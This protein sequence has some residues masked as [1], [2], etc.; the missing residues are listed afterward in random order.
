[1]LSVKVKVSKHSP[2]KL[3]FATNIPL[4]QGIVGIMGHSGCG[5]TTLLRVLTGLETRY[6]GSLSV[7]GN[8]LWDSE[9]KV[10]VPTHQ[11]GIG[12]VFQDARLFPHLTVLGNLQ[13]AAKRA[14]EQRFDIPQV[15]QWFGLT[16]LLE[17]PATTLSGGQKQRLAV[18][19]AVLQSPKLLLLDEPF[20]ALDMAARNELLVCLKKMHIQ[21]KLPMLF[22]SHDIADIRQLCEYLLVMEQGK[23]VMNGETLHLLNQLSTGLNLA[24][25]IA[26]TFCCSGSQKM[27]DLPL[28]QLHVGKQSLTTSQILSSWQ[29]ES[30]RCVIH[31]SDVGICLHPISDCSIANCIAVTV[32]DVQS[33][34]EQHMMISLDCEGQPLYSQITCYSQ[35]RLKLAP[36]QKA[37]A[38]F[39]AS[40]V[41]LI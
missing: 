2:T 4:D 9:Q 7:N 6:Q 15:V 21:T 30:I 32:T 17:A 31:A 26:A 34:N 13:F 11:R 38:L 41:S 39:K 36:G 40:A 33:I 12:L 14:Q 18:A 8:A 28:T 37:Y 25:P 1:M 19:R 16:D 20:V 24:Q 3:D 27:A 35:Q 5:K 10:D 23:I 29:S 22:V